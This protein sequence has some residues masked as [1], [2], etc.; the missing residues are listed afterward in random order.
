LQSSGEK[1]M[2]Y[3]RWV[4]VLTSLA[5]L[6]LCTSTTAAL[7]T[8]VANISRVFAQVSSSPYLAG[9]SMILIDRS[10]GEI[11]FQ[12]DATSL[13]KPAS[14]LKL[15]STSAAM[16][17]LDPNYKYV[18]RIA[19]G[20]NPR[21]LVISGNLDPWMTGSYFEA[22]K[23]HRAWLQYLV[24]RS[25][26][27]LKAEGATPLRSVS[28][29]YS[30]LYSND[31]SF[32]KHS[33]V[34]MG[35]T[36]KIKE[37]S[38]NHV[39]SVSGQE[40]ATVTSPTVSQMVKFALTWSDNLLAERLARAA[41]HAIGYPMNDAGVAQTIKR[42]LVDLNVDQSGLYIYDASGLS[43][44]DRV[45]A[46]LIADLLLKIRGNEKFA[47][48]YEGLPISGISGTLESRFINTAPQAVG[49]I[50]AKTGTL[51]GTVSLAGYVESG[52]HEYVFVAIADHI[53]KGAT[54]AN[55][56]RS[57]LDRLL[58]KITAPLEVVKASTP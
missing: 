39:Q 45:T 43:H 4:W 36:P 50:H 40:I 5:S 20:L 44:Q 58:G 54:A 1:V 37:I 53:R 47:A 48:V 38:A 55:Q 8:P 32:L 41:S 35:I 11:V 57:T 2:K 10:N 34:A 16:Q 22:K 13:R 7:A 30:G 6:A 19:K 25:V 27:D 28:I 14:V 21:T 18:T 29:Q 56:A 26:A 12:T 42:L 51:D 31:I 17:Y 46:K 24:N 23:Y 52:T 3:L 15:L 49:L 33:Y 9:P